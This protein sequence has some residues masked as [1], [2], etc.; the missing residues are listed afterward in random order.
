[1][2]IT[3]AKTAGFCFGVNRAVS[4]VEDLV[5]EGKRVCTLGPI[6]HN[7]QLVEELKEKGVRVVSAPKEAEKGE[8]LVIR[9]H[10]VPAAVYEEALV[11]ATEV[12]DATCPFVAKIHSIV[13]SAAE[14]NHTV[15]IAGDPKHHEVIG[16]CGN[17]ENTPTFVF[18]NAEELEKILTEN[19]NFEKKSI[20]AVSQTTFNAEIWSE[21][22]KILKKGCTNAFVFD[23][24]CN[25]TA[26]RQQEAYC[27]SKK[28]DC[29]IVI[30][31]QHSSNTAK[32]F[33]VCSANCRH[34]YFV[35]TAADLKAEWYVG[36]EN[37]GVVAGASTPAHIIKE[38]IKTMSENLQ[39]VEQVEEAVQK[40]FE[41]MTDEEAFEASLS[42][43]T[44]DQK[45]T[46]TVLAVSENE[47]QVDIGRG[48]AGY[49][50]KEE[51]SADPNADILKEVSVGDTMNLI[52]MRTN[53]QEGIVMLSKRRFDAIAGW[54]N[55]VA[56][57][58]SGEILTG[59]VKDI[60]KG[61]VTVF[62]NGIRVFIPASQ[63]TLSKSEP[64]DGLKGKEVRFQI[65]EIGRGRRAVGSI[66]NVLK[67]ERK[68]A[69]S[70]V[71]ESIAVGDRFV[72]KVKSL[73]SYGAFVDLGGV[74][75]MVH[76]SELSWQKIK[77]PSEV[78]LVGDE[79]EVYVKAIDTE[80]KK[81][82][83][84]YKKPE[85]NPWVIF[86]KNFAVDDTVKATVVSMTTYGA[87]AR[88][89]PGIDGLVHISQIANKHVAKP[90]DELTIGQEIEAKIIAVD[91][92][93]KRVSLS[94]RALLPEEAAAEEAV[95]EA[96]EEATEE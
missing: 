42:A 83:L 1:M 96:A 57:K 87:F 77:N 48:L 2:K 20:T 45:V 80:K 26:M 33:D 35:S 63:A 74:D 88:I 91:Y 37:V 6:I 92:E 7:E 4:M 70:K 73:T 46:G 67:E 5:K 41:E 72:G 58:D 16:I 27:L 78:V 79:V 93:K 76:I 54:D 51:Y 36:K 19:N 94:I 15:L 8:T 47:I 28:S 95:E 85:E 55:I 60:I 50:S 71:W 3:V 22:Q 64:L 18:S 12:C 38:V 14:Q 75:G 11:C 62:C 23:T 31:G 59:L 68:A 81:I 90:Q 61:G 39:S 29:M 89:I 44:G 25:A 69:A 17:A 53:D 13:K 34:T 40:S 9:S 24:I 52:I 10:G 32:L 86:E 56:A 21:C 65:I 82:S 84:G 66:R 43:L 30:G 49:V